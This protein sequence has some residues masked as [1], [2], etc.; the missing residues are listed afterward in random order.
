MS[1]TKIKGADMETETTKKVLDLS[2][3]T[4]YLEWVEEATEAIEQVD[5]YAKGLVGTSAESV[6]L[7]TV[8]ELL[9]QVL[10][11]KAELVATKS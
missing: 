11:L 1:A 4:E 10:K 8:N 7:E 6:V 9:E 5:E 3:L 2:D